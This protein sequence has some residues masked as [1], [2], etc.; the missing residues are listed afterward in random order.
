MATM[1]SKPDNFY[2]RIDKMA[3][4]SAVSF[5]HMPQR[6]YMITGAVVKY[7]PSVFMGDGSELRKNIMFQLRDE[8]ETSE[9][10]TLEA[11]LTS[12]KLLSSAFKDGALKTKIT[13]STVKVFNEQKE[14]IESP[15]N[16][17]D[18]TVN[19]LVVVK[20]VWSSKNLTGLALEVTDIQILSEVA[21]PCPF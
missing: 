6:S 11:A 19:C 15:E 5:E 21:L 12:S 3:R 14:R 4:S 18:L 13:P 16:W 10:V 9:I 17:K 20:G 2:L 8:G 7:Q 1:R